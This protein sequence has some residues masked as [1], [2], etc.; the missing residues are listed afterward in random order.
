[1]SQSTIN[2]IILKAANGKISRNDSLLETLSK[3]C[4]FS[5]DQIDG[6]SIGLKNK[7][8]PQN[9]DDRSRYRTFQWYL[10]TTPEEHT[11]ILSHSDELL[12]EGWDAKSFE[13]KESLPSEDQTSDLYVRMPSYKP[14]SSPQDYMYTVGVRNAIANRVSIE[15]EKLASRGFLSSLPR[16]FCRRDW[17][18]FITSPSLKIQFD[19]EVSLETRQ[20]IRMILRQSYVINDS[21][22]FETHVSCD[23][24][25]QQRR[26][27]PQ[28][29]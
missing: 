22:E 20:W 11:K 25:R 6:M 13:M 8:R 15:L 1:M 18:G 28:E 21:G 23:W 3:V 4:G 29:R 26:E 9:N 12:K 27:S 19:D 14:H 2:Q 10:I 5:K 24:W 7:A 16:I 17:R